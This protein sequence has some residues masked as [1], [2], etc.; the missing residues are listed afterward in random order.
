[1]K[2]DFITYL[3]Y[4]NT[5]NLR[6]TLYILTKNKISPVLPTM[7]NENHINLYIKKMFSN[8]NAW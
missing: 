2:I 1:M 6:S 4:N 7:D 8:K 5:Y 3:T